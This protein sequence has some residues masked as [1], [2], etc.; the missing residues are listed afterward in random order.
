[1]AMAGKLRSVR[2]RSISDIN[3][4]LSKLIN[5]VNRDEMDPNKATK[6]GNLCNSLATGLRKQDIEERISKLEAMVNNNGKS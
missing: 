5:M 6:I 1:M 4:F 2:L 3:R